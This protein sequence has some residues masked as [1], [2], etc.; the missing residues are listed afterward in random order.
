MVHTYVY[1]AWFKNA[2]RSK[3]LRMPAALAFSKQ[4]LS[5]LIAL[6]SRSFRAFLFVSRQMIISASAKLETL[7]AIHSRTCEHISRA[8]D[9]HK[10]SIKG[11]FIKNS[12]RKKNAIVTWTCYKKYLVS[13]S[14]FHFYKS[15]LDNFQNRLEVNRAR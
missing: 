11:L 10:K 5:I 7:A 13:L 3:K 12:Q 9:T 14:F 8:C 15:H 2:D 1:N 6:L 4:P